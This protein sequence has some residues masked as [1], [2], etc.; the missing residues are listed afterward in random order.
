MTQIEL[1]QLHG[2]IQDEAQACDSPLLSAHY[3]HMLLALRALIESHGPTMEYYEWLVQFS[4]R[5]LP[6]QCTFVV[7]L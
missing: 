5:N 7:D 4:P 2:Q 3:D 1:I 6:N